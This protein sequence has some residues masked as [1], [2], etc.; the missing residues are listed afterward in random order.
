MGAPFGYRRTVTGDLVEDLVTAPIVRRIF[1]EYATGSHTT[2]SLAGR[3]NDEGIRN[4]R[5]RAWLP[6]TVAQTVGNVA[7]IGKTNSVS[8]RRR[9]GELRVGAWA[10]LRSGVSCSVCSSTPCTSRTVRSWLTRRV[11]T[12]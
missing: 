9:E 3:L 8:R 4:G 2:R 6:Y 7:Y 10:P 12:A 5:G 1:D 11:R